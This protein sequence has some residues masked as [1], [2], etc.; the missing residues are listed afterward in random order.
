MQDTGKILLLYLFG[1]VEGMLEWQ[2]VV[3]QKQDEAMSSITQLRSSMDM[4][5]TMHKALAKKLN[6]LG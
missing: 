3:D 2:G 1:K 5:I 6:V 4:L